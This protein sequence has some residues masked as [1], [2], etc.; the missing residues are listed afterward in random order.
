MDG[1]LWHDSVPI[2]DLPAIFARIRALG[3]KF[4][5]A[6]NNATRTVHEYQEKFS[7]F[8]RDRRAVADRHIGCSRFG[9][10]LG[11]HFPDVAQYS[12]WARTA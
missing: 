1:V 8:R 7:G 9:H 12:S 5:L 4:A 2:G 11:R 6:T 10:A 3:L